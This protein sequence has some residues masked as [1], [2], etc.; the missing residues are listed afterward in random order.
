M[1]AVAI[2]GIVNL[3]SALEMLPD[4]DAVPAQ[5]LGG[6]PLY[7]TDAVNVVLSTTPEIVSREPPAM[8]T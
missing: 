4:I 5:E 3:T 2:L 6:A 8:L 7:C 1:P